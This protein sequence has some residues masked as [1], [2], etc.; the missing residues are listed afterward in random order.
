M[1]LNNKK[2]DYFKYYFVEYIPVFVMYL[3]YI[4]AVLPLPFFLYTDGYRLWIPRLTYLAQEIVNFKFPLWNEY[5]FCGMPLFADGNTNVINPATSLFFFMSPE[6]AYTFD[7]LI[8]YLILLL[9][10]WLYFRERKYSYTAA[11]VGTLGYSFCG[12]TIFWSLF[13]GMNL[14]L[15]L[16]PWTMFF[17]NKMEEDSQVKWNIL[18]YI[19]IL[20]SALGGF[21]QFALISTAFAVIEGLKDYSFKRNKKTIY[22]RLTIASLGVLSASVIIIP[23][24]ES[25]LFSHRKYI[26]YFE[27]CLRYYYC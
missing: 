10:T 4:F 22:E 7:V 14:A 5:M 9:G 23:T 26:S 24:I 15:A 3:S 25:A 16:F 19:T 6:W 21:I 12:L 20:I 13:H 11:I 17:F 18:A 8:I 27:G 2:S 1:K